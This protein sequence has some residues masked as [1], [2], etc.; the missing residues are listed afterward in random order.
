MPLFGAIEKGCPERKRDVEGER[1]AV[2]HR[3]LFF[4]ARKASCCALLP[5][6]GPVH[7]MNGAKYANMM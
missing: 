7:L 1:G 4:E 5:L 6:E 3:R 2:A